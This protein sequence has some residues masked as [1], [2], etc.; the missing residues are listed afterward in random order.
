MWVTTSKVEPTK[1]FIFFS[2]IR[3]DLGS[4]VQQNARRWTVRASPSTTWGLELELGLEWQGNVVYNW[5]QVWHSTI[6]ME[7]ST[8]TNP[9]YTASIDMLSYV[10]GTP[11]RYW[12]IGHVSHLSSDAW[13]IHRTFICPSYP[14]NFTHILDP[15]TVGRAG[16]SI[17]PLSI[18]E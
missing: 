8:I 7:L 12:Y 3:H 6:R 10:S 11:H 14:A 13:T 9:D 17:D 4:P 15:C 5:M 16:V 2:P 18:T 1:H